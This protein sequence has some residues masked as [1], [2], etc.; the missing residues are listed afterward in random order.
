MLPQVL[1]LGW[2]YP[3]YINGGLGV[4]SQ[5]LAEAMGEFVNLQLVVPQAQGIAHSRAEIM[6]LD[7]IPHPEWIE[8]TRVQ[9]STIPVGL[10]AYPTTQTPDSLYQGD[11]AEKVHHYRKL[12][13]HLAKNRNFDLVHAH[14]WMTFPAGMALRKAHHKPL[15]LH[16]HSTEYDRSGPQSHNWIYRLEKEAFELAD[17]IIPVSQ[18]T[19]S[20]LE[21]EYGISAEKISPVHNAIHLQKG[22]RIPKPFPEKLV[23]F[24]GRITGQKGPE[25][26]LNMSMKVLEHYDQVRFMLAGMGDQRAQIMELAARFRIGDRFHCVGFLESAEKQRMLGMADLFVMPSMSEPFGLVALEAAQMGVPCLISSQ[27]GVQEILPGAIAID[28][29]DLNQMA[30][31]VISLLKYPS[32]AETIV[33]EQKKNLEG[34]SWEE[35]AVKLINLYREKL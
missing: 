30:H 2:E 8:E 31:Y 22:I 18:Y 5:G 6:G 17:L 32:L 26:F 20:I 16:V 1:M 23:V 21:R 15:V 9:V 29:L 27:S 35:S 24:M 34:V 14:D 13:V 25:Q 3:P 7:Q 11:L 28:P 10:Q 19:A 12:V 4:A 33:Q